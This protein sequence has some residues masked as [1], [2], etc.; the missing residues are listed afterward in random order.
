MANRA[1][2]GGSS[3]P[4]ALR[5]IDRRTSSGRYLSQIERE[6][7]DHLGPG[8]ISPPQRY[9]IE[10]IAADLLRLRLLDAEMAAGTFS[11]HDARVAH[12]LRNAVRLALREIGVERAPPA[13]PI[14]FRDYWTRPVDKAAA[15]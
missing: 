1:R 6:L 14:S 15:T 3:R 4:N 2:L 13:K 5:R 10:R 12:A 9:L 8:R 11:A 7:T